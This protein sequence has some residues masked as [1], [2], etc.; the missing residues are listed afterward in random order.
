[1]ATTHAEQDRALFNRIAESYCSKDLAQASRLA[2]QQRLQ[3][4]L[5]VANLPNDCRILEVG[6]GA[7]FSAAY[8]EGNYGEYVGVDYADNLID[9][10]R[11]HHGG[12]CVEFVAADIR[13]FQTDR[14]FDAV[15]MV[16][17]LHH[18][19]E[20]QSILNDIVQLVK[21]GGWILANEPQ[22]G[23]PIVRA[24][25]QVRKVVDSHYSSDQVELSKHDLQQFYQAADLVEVSM[26]PQGIFSTPFAEVILSPQSVT[27]RVSSLA[28]MIDA[29]LEDRTPGLLQYVSWNLI[30]AGRRA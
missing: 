16:G 27:R 10:A 15:L 8:L 7:G 21:P 30:A 2:R 6:C 17:V 18:F 5:A 26:T 11:E 20:I 4:T 12:E 13:E 24:A 23:N 3:Q 19:D 25:R 29:L 1:M 9:Y 28:C 14:P 22:P